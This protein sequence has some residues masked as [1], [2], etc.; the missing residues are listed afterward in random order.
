MQCLVFKSGT[1]TA[2]Q[3]NSR[4]ADYK[5]SQVDELTAGKWTLSLRLW[6]STGTSVDDWKARGKDYTRLPVPNLPLCYY[7]SHLFD[8]RAPSSSDVPV[9][10]L[11]QPIVWAARAR[12]GTSRSHT[13]NIVPARLA[14][15]D[16]CTRFRSSLLNNNDLSL[17]WFQSSQRS[18]NVFTLAQNLSDMWLSTLEN[19]AALLRSV[20]EMAP[21]SSFLCVNRSPI[22][23]GSRTY[24]KDCFLLSWGNNRDC[25][26]TMP[27]SLKTM[28][29]QIKGDQWNKR[30]RTVQVYYYPVGS[31]IGVL[32]RISYTGVHRTHR[33]AKRGLMRENSGSQF[34]EKVNSTFNSLVWVTVNSSVI[35]CLYFPVQRWERGV[36]LR[37]MMTARLASATKRILAKMSSY[38][39]RRKKVHTLLLSKL[40]IFKWA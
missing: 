14:E 29:V 18:K 7:S 5:I 19:G 27:L 40:N 2:D 6:N 13:P 32:T 36:R 33:E 28:E 34:L 26:I 16:W 38:L 23:G 15:R 12:G 37:M 22:R 24:L 31:V 10:L 25:H 21:K 4:C 39:F 17:S 11:N 8:L 9:L 3:C 35:A 30:F 20:T 1:L